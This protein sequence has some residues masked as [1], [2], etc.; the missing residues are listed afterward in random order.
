MTYFGNKRGEVK[1][2]EK[3]LADFNIDVKLQALRQV[4]ISK[5]RHLNHV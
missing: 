5:D 4:Y 3:S 1:E 2:L